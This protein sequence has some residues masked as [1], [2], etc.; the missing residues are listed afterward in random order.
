MWPLIW[1]VLV[2]VGLGLWAWLG[3]RI[4]V[5][6]KGL[7]RQY[8][9]TSRALHRA[10]RDADAAHTTWL[11]ERA[12]QDEGYHAALVEAARP[13]IRGLRVETGNHDVR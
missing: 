13:A 8:G 11:T 2:L 3:R 12:L 6:V 7:L 5:A 9:E 10:G 1:V 4:F